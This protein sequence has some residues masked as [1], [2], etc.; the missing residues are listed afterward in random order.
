[1]VKPHN[2]HDAV[3]CSVDSLLKLRRLGSDV[4]LHRTK[5][6]SSQ[7]DGSIASRFRGRGMEFAEVRPYTPGDDIRTIDWRVT[8]R[9]QVTHT[10]LFQEERE[11]PVFIVLDQRSTMF[12]GTQTEFKSVY[13][14]KLAATIAWS[15]LASNDRIGA[16]ILGDDNAK[17]IRPKRGKHA[18]LN[19]LHYIH[20]FNQALNTPTGQA[21]A[22]SL[23]EQLDDL[24]RVARPGSAIYIISDFNDVAA[25]N[26]PEPNSSNPNFD[27]ALSKLS[28][29]CDVS[30]IKLHDAFEANLPAAQNLTFSNGLKRVSVLT[31]KKNMRDFSAQFNAKNIY[32]NQLAQRSGAYFTDIDIARPL[33]DALHS[34]FMSNRSQRRRR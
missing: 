16:I 29:F 7:I 18:L 27:Q 12:F 13:A 17:D 23:H 32:L 1:M 11:R 10:K 2:Q 20:V 19:V 4:Q 6:T 15:A 21:P 28:R 22:I 14:A 25:Q 8:A 24:S 3:Y 33:D 9:T 30:L 5:R 34:I 26:E 31:N